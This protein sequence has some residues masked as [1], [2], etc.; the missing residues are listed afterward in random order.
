MF[1]GMWNLLYSQVHSERTVPI[2]M[3]GCITP[4]R[5][6]HISTFRSKIWRHHHVPRPRLPK[7]RED[8]G[9]SHTFKADIGLLNICMGF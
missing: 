9:D 1:R 7:W 2:I 3:A 6:G 4:E 5:S 8:F